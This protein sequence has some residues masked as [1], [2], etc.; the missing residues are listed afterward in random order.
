MEAYVHGVSTRSVDEL[1]EALGISSGISR[2]EVSRICAGL[3][4]HVSAFERYWS[5]AV[6]GLADY[7][8]LVRARNRRISSLS[9]RNLG[10]AGFDRV[11]EGLGPP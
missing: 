5:V 4:E 8:K 10:K 1:V 11:L 7:A 9:V 6:P 2:S 3:D